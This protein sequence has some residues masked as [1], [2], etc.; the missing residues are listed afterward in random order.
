MYTVRTL[1][2]WLFCSGIYLSKQGDVD[3]IRGDSSG[4]VD[5]MLSSVTIYNINLL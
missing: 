5:T 3:M 4:A 1:P 2:Q